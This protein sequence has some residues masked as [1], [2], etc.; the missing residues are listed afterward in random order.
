MNISEPFIRR[1]VMTILVMAALLIFGAFGYLKLPISELPNVDFPT[2]RVSASLP[3]A[4]PQTMASAV[5]TPLEAEFS[6]IAGIS[7]MTSSSSQGST[8]ITIQF[9]LDRNIDAAAQDVQSAIAATARKLP[10][11][12]PSPPTL[13]KVNPADSSILYISMRSPAL[14]LQEVDK[15]AE[16]LL[17]RQ[18][19]TVEGVAQVNVYGGQQFAVR[20]QVDPT[21]LAARGIG[22]DQV[23]AAAANANPN[24]PTGSFNGPSQA[25]LIHA[26]GQMDNAADFAR[27]IVVY[28][29][30]A[31][32][33]LKDVGRVLDSVA[34]DK[35]A[36]WYNGERGILLAIQRQPGSNTIAVVDAIKKILPQFKE[37]LPASVKLDVTYDRSESIRAS[38]ADVQKTLV[39]A[40]VL[41]IAVIFVFLRTLSAT[42]VASLALPLAVVGTFAG[43]SYLGYNLDN[44]SLMALTLSV[45]FVVD[46]AIVMLENIVRHVERGE[47]PYDAAL[48]GS[49]EIGFT[50]LSMTV[51]L[52]AV[53]IP[54]LFMGGIVG[55][56][57]HEFAMTIVIAILV[58]GIVSVTLTPMLLSRLLKPGKEAHHGKFYE[59]SER[60][61]DRLQKGYE[62][63]LRWS[64]RH[65]FLIF[66]VFVASL[67]ATFGMFAISKID[68][69]PSTDSGQIIGSTE[70]ATRTSFA[71][72]V[73]Y[74]K[75]AAAIISK[76]P[77][78]DGVMSS[79]SGGSSS[80][81]N[82][83]SFFLRLKPYGERP[84]ADDIIQELRPKLAHLPGMNVYLTNPPAIRIGGTQSKSQYQYTLQA[85]DQDVLQNSATRLMNALATKPGFQDVTSDLDLSTPA[86][87]IVID[88]DK[89]AALGVTPAAIET[90]LGAAYGGG[91]ISQIYTDIDTYQVILELLPEYRAD[92]SSLS[93]LYVTA[94]DGAT[95]VPLTA[96]TK[97]GPGT[98]PLT[99]NHLGQLPA[100]T[101]SFNLE[102]GVALSD[103]VRTIEETQREIRLPA[104]VQ[105]SF[106]GT[107]QAFQES[108]SSMT[109]LLILAVVVIYIILG[110]LYESFIHPLTILSGLP[111]AAVGALLTLFVF[112]QLYLWG[113]VPSDATLSLYAFVGMIM[114]IGIVKK[115]AIM[116]IDFALVRQRGENA[117]PEDAIYEA[118]IV[119]FRPIMMTTAAAFMGTLPIAI[120]IGA[121]SEAR[122]PL[123]L[124]VV[125]G[126]VLSQ[127][128]TLYI[129]PVIYIYLD[130][131]GSRTSH[132]RGGEAQPHPAE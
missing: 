36:S 90:A 8:T 57:L 94:A 37:Q 71:K 125:G 81:T 55:R 129:T 5:A 60:S 12:M 115:N 123:G 98:M 96:V 58:S 118:A 84:N 2:I 31:P 66:L 63:S 28:R 30:G 19:S 65:R 88:R 93:K 18:I 74:Q 114:L 131:L 17:A 10:P 15:Y 41:V 47:K 52:A 46:D 127:L 35:V 104:T 50:I 69:L 22:I 106:Q 24:V 20:I 72:M 34:N 130:E 95:L 117:K 70:A 77:Y 44:L 23:A 56:L 120:G 33:R 103:A 119:R 51:S 132:W 100:I 110:I 16:T 82:T 111:S 121:G 13:R 40:A 86:V 128:L 87:D 126:L 79:V 1:P 89:A 62:R 53:F 113:I 108:T 29:N 14:P 107:A 85:L 76:D 42:F 61:F 64:L 43:M 122:Q 4:D 99:V 101:I 75:E 78:I 7:S 68:F 67:A 26:T 109:V 73:E 45:G 25:T 124:A 102:P 38:V 3:G 54:V 83:G 80:K 9:D 97:I 92:T 21:E 112:H 91:Q 11:E 32:V 6:T 116:M 49:K 48:K 59:W 105:T 39:I 27:Q